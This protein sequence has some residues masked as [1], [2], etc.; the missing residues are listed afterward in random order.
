MFA[1]LSLTFILILLSGIRKVVLNGQAV[2]SSY[3][4][5]WPKAFFLFFFFPAEPME[6]LGQGLDPP[7]QQGPEP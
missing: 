5:R 1:L 3:I 2:L 7:S 4:G 6:I